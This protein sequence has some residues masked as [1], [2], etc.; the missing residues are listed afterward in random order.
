MFNRVRII[1]VPHKKERKKKQ[2][3]YCPINWALTGAVLNFNDRLVIHRGGGA[4]LAAV[5]LACVRVTVCVA[6]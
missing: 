6:G 3:H 2:S 4:L 5:C 1:V